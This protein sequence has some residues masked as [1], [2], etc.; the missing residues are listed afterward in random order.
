MR[1]LITVVLIVLVIPMASLT[2]LP[3]SRYARSERETLNMDDA[4]RRGVSGSFVRLSDGVTHYQLGGPAAGATLV[5]IPGFSTPYNVWDPTYDGLTAAGARVLRYEL[6]G[7]GWSDRPSARYD[8]D[9]YDRQIVDLL[10][11]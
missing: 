7:R 3:I 9:F 1:P 8:A 4:A 6:Y 2:L 10:N 5:L 11:A